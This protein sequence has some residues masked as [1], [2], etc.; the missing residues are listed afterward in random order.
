MKQLIIFLSFFVC[1]LS[2]TA[3]NR[4]REITDFKEKWN[5]NVSDMKQIE[6]NS[7]PGNLKL[8]G[9]DSD[10]LDIKVTGSDTYKLTG[11]ATGLGF[12]LSKNKKGEYRIQGIMD[13]SKEFNITYEISIPNTTVLK[14]QSGSRFLD[15]ST[16]TISKMK[17]LLKLEKIKGD[18]QLSDVQNS[19]T[20]INSKGG[21]DV[22]FTELIQDKPY[23]IACAGKIS[24]DIPIQSKINLKM[25]LYRDIIINSS[26]ALKGEQINLKKYQ[27]LLEKGEYNYKINGGGNL[28]LLHAYKESI[29]LK[30]H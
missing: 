15:Q 14:I 28:F 12:I 26:K 24:L 18:I 3:Q 21:I 11:G 25:H 30:F 5:L 1:F 2:T 9:T 20:A 8:V 29:N 23:S 7:L 6:I 4:Q 13:N 19:L 27:N 16:W 17:S 22:H 10:V